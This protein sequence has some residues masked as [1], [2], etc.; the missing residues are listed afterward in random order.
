MI[1]FANRFADRDERLREAT[2][3][4]PI[5]V[6]RFVEGIRYRW[7]GRAMMHEIVIAPRNDQWVPR[8]RTRATTLL[9][10]SVVPLRY[11]GV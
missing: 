1:V 11:Q 5:C 9:G 8:G 7:Y 3:Q 6:A 2:Q 4:H 10:S